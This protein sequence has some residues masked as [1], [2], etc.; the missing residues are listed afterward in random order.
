MVGVRWGSG[1]GGPGGGWGGGLGMVRFGG[2]VSRCHSTDRLPKLWLLHCIFSQIVRNS[3]D[4]ANTLGDVLSRSCMYGFGISGLYSEFD[5]TT[6]DRLWRL[7][8]T[9]IGFKGY[10]TCEWTSWYF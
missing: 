10:D 4:R 3:L 6:K 7:N 9:R 1:D 5:T 2:A 8:C